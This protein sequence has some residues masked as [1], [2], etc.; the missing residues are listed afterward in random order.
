MSRWTRCQSETYW[1]DDYQTTPGVY[2]IYVDGELVYIGQSVNIRNRLKM[3]NIR[4]SYGNSIIV[5]WGDGRCKTCHVKVSYSKKYGDWA[6]RE[7]RLIKRLKP[8]FNVLHVGR[9]LAA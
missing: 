1:Y 6:M 3:H 8:K 7:L 2:A 9:R 5:P 4:Y